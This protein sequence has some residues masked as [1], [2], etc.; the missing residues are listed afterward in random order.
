MTPHESALAA[1]ETTRNIILL[2]EMS[3]VESDWAVAYNPIAL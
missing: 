1:E 3:S 2:S